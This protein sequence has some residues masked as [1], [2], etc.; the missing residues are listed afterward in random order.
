MTIFCEEKVLKTILLKSVMKNNER[1]TITRILVRNIRITKP[2]S[3]SWE[4]HE[5][6]DY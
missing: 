5:L 4:D 3:L 1:V 2:D 6:N